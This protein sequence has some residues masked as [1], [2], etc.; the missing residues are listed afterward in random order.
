MAE[1][2]WAALLVCELVGPCRAQQ[3]ARPRGSAAR[4]CRSRAHAKATLFLQG[5]MGAKQHPTA[6]ERLE[7]RTGVRVELDRAASVAVVRAATTGGARAAAGR[8]QALLLK[9]STEEIVLPPEAA[10]MVIGKGG[11][12]IRAI[13]G[14]TGAQLRIA[15]DDG[16]ATLRLRGEAAAIEAAR[17][18]V[19]AIVEDVVRPAMVKVAVADVPRVL[20]AGG[21]T[22]KLIEAET[23]AKLRL[24]RS[25]T[26]TSTRSRGT[27]SRLPGAATGYSILWLCSSLGLALSPRTGARVVHVTQR[28]HVGSDRREEGSNYTVSVG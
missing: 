26:T 27:A 19:S 14:D 8:R 20:G 5:A 18:R 17:A 9:I 2:V 25:T 21:A 23:G 4:T 3:A 12:T 15:R 10:S 13:E 7:R 11:S 16:D 22:S 24:E 28:E 1:V 6:V